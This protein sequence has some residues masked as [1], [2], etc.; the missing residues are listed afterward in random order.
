MELEW[1][2]IL[3]E[4]QFFILLHTL[5]FQCLWVQLVTMLIKTISFSYKT[6]WEAMGEPSIYKKFLRIKVHSLDGT[7]NDFETDKFTLTVETE[8]DYVQGSESSLSLDFGGGALGWG[9]SA[10]GQFPWGE[11]RL[12]QLT[13]KLKSKKAKALRVVFTNNT[14]HQNVLISGYELEIAAAYDLQIK[15]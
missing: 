10:W 8:H 12:E 1:Q 5:G 15:E 13:S 9:N 7:I 2:D 11:S 3:Q 14:R 6:H 4:H